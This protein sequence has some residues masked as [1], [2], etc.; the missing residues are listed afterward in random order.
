MTARRPAQE[1]GL[2][3]ALLIMLAPFAWSS[4][5]RPDEMDQLYHG[6]RLLA[7][8]V[9]YRDFFEILT[10]LSPWLAA[11]I[12]AVA[13]PSLLAARAVT[14]LAIAVAGWLAYR[15]VR[16]TGGGAAAGVLAALALAYGVFRVFPVWNHHWIAL[17][18]GLG[19]VACA[20]RGY[21]DARRRWWLAAGVLAGA[22]AWTT[23]TDGIVVALALAGAL[24]LWGLLGPT[25]WRLIGRQAAWLAAGG[26]AVLGPGVLALAWQGTLAEAWHCVWVWPVSHY[27]VAGGVN[28]I[29]VGSDLA[30]LLSPQAEPWLGRAAFLARV[31]HVVALYVLTLGAAATALAWGLSRLGAR[32]PLGERE[33]R[34][35][36]LALATLGFTA[37]VLRGR[38]DYSHLALYAPWSL[39]VAALLADRLRTLAPAAAGPLVPWLPLGALA[40]FA[41][42]GGARFAAEVQLTPDQWLSTRGPDA[43]LADDEA[44][45]FIRAHTA[46]GDR[47]VSLPAGGLHYF[48]GRPAAT[49]MALLLP[50]HVRYNDEADHRALRDEIR[51][52]RPALVIVT[53]DQPDPRQVAAYLVHPLEGYEP[54]G[55]VDS[56][57]GATPQRSWVFRRRTAAAGQ[58]GATAQ[59]FTR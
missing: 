46:P 25:P 44:I 56:R 15:L 38:S 2:V 35:G 16:L 19:A 52:N 13:G 39:V 10:P 26:L 11:A 20:M 45:R 36:L 54:A 21:G 53:P 34:F 7:G 49:S 55:V 3:L 31:Y 42:T 50:L 48:Y 57:W 8:E 41:A 22:T 27:R 59:S 1:I 58:A 40:L 18:L 28:D 12:F 32:R 47:I 6:L 24:A 51:R 43:R 14:C 9:L 30:A 5:T 23:Q 33:A 4:A 17:P 29:L 37:A